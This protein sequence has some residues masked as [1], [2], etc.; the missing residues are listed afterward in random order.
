[1]VDNRT[2]PKGL[3]QKQYSN[4]DNIEMETINKQNSAIIVEK[5]I[6]T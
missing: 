6:F 3:V 5:Y 2:T 4:N 1:M